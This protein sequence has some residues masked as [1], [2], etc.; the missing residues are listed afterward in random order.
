MSILNLQGCKSSSVYN[1]FIFFLLKKVADI[2]KL[3]IYMLYNM[4][5][6]N[7]INTINIIGFTNIKC[8]ISDNVYILKKYIHNNNLNAKVNIISLFD[9]NNNN[10]QKLINNNNINNNIFCIQPFEIA[11]NIGNSFEIIKFLN[12]NNKKPSV[13]W[14]WEFKSLPQIFKTYEKYFHTIYVQ[15]QFCY[16]IFSKNLTVSIKKLQLTSRIHDYID[17]LS[18]HNIQN[19]NINKIIKDTIGKVRIGYC[20]DLNSSII[21]KNA[22]NL[23]KAF[24]EISN[25]KEKNLALIIKYRLPRGNQFVNSLEERLFQDFIH[26]SNISKNIYLINEELA[27][28]DL[29]KLYTHFDYYISPHCGE[30]FGITIYDNMILGNKIISPYYSGE[31]AYLKRD[32]IIE[33]KY[34][35]KYI[36]GFKKHP[37]YGQMNDFTAAYVSVDS[38]KNTIMNLKEVN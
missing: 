30:G 32:K 20:F 1:I 28:L 31:K 17:A 24:N 11:R 19:M 4:T 10:I 16:M 12:L 21:R 33:L 7:T 22:L 34:E 36:E 15:S 29:Y 38:I 26:I 37:I 27:L 14:V 3:K 18:E 25:N 13:L 23:V 6:I 9:I 2:I 5:T 35:E 8:S